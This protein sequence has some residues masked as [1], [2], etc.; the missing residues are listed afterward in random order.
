[1][2]NLI[3]ILRSI[4]NEKEKKNIILHISSLAQEINFLLLKINFCTDFQQANRYFDLLEKIQLIL[5]TIQHKLRINLPNNLSQFVKDFDDVYDLET[6]KN[7]FAVIKK[8]QTLYNPNYDAMISKYMFE[9]T[10]SPPAGDLNSQLQFLRN[11]LIRLIGSIKTCKNFSEAYQ[12]FNVLENLHNC[13]A[14][15]LFKYDITLDQG[16]NDFVRIFDRIDDPHERQ[17]LYDKIKNNSYYVH[18]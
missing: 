8:N 16:L 3:E 2:H 10:D 7:L 17:Y 6:R 18:Y 12:Y 15:I 1:M 14:M 11:Q 13:L 9:I 4:E 5:A